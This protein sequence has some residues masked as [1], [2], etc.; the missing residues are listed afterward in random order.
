LGGH[1]QN[2]RQ[3]TEKWGVS[4]VAPKGKEEGNVVIFVI[5]YTAI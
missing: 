3:L 4:G 1:P 2:Y 5:F